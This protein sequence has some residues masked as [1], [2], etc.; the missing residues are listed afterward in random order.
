MNYTELTNNIQDICE[1]TFTSSQIALFVQQAEQNIA[2]LVEL[3]SFRKNSVATVTAGNQYLT[4][5]NNF[6]RLYSLA[7]DNNGYEYLRQKDVSFIR[8]AYPSAAS[9]SVPKYYAI[10]DENTILLGPTPD[11]DYTVELHY[12][13]VPPSIVDEGTTWLGETY[14][15]ALLN[16]TLVEALRF[17]KGESDLVEFYQQLYMQSITLLKQLSDN[18]VSDTYTL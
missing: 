10:F 5:P 7:V 8:E 15:A 18:M 16:G 6:V 9:E 14:D 17:Q 11:S 12:K 2:M 1:T 3:P 13:V 4:T